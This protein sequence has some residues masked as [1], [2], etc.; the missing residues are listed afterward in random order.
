MIAV[1]RHR[2]RR[3][4]SSSRLRSNATRRHSRDG[5]ICESRR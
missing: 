5:G 3:V 4:D 1:G 2:L